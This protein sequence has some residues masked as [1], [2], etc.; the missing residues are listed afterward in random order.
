MGNLAISRDLRLK[1]FAGIT[2]YENIIEYFKIIFLSDRR[3]YMD[4]RF[5]YMKNNYWFLMWYDLTIV[6]RT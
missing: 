5:I 2:Y 1:C 6:F 4:S 3:C